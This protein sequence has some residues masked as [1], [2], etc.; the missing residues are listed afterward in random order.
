MKLNRKIRKLK[1]KLFSGAKNDALS[2]C[3][4]IMRQVEI[5]RDREVSL[6]VRGH[7]ELALIAED[8]IRMHI[9]NVKRLYNVVK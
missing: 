8:V 7:V 5:L 9:R 4:L 3:R 1:R 2:K 6:M